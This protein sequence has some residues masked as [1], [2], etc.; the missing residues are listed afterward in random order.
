MKKSLSKTIL[1]IVFNTFVFLIIINFLI[2]ILWPLYSSQTHT[3]H[4]F[5]PEQAKLLN[6]SEKDLIILHNETWRNFD[7]F[8]FLPFIGHTETKRVGKFV[9]FTEEDGRKVNRPVSCKKNLIMYGGSTTFGYNVTDNQTIASYLQEYLGKNFCVYN[10]GRAYFY[11]KQENNLFQ[12]HIEEKKKID[13]AIF[14]D[15]VNERCGSY[16]YAH[17]L[18]NSF[19]FLTERPYKMWRTA[20][21]NFIYSLP[22]SQFFNSLF[23]KGRWINDPKNNILDISQCKKNIPLDFLF[24]KRISSRNAICRTYEVNCFTFLQPF[25]RISGK[26]L[27]EVR[28]KKI[29]KLN[30]KYDVLKKIVRKNFLIDLQY[31]LQNDNDNDLSYID[32]THYTPSSNDKIAFEISKLIFIN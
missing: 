29:D 10:H 6:L 9:N 30:K 16:E 22:I 27:E 23:G 24:E 26:T 7:K 5:Q 31:V 13:Y 11:S 12:N 14:L 17:H 15:G 25:P 19:N 18:N 3:K 20:S 1:I 4:N 28:G 21:V 2:I 32:A 8:K